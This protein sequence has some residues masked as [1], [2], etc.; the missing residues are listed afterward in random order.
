VD[1]D[2]KYDV[3]IGNEQYMPGGDGNL[4]PVKKDR[5]PPDL[6]HLNRVPR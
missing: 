4:M 1:R 6:R 5:L 3:I 2:G